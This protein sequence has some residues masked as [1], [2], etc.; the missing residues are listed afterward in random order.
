MHPSSRQFLGLFAGFT[1]VKP[2]RTQDRQA[3][4]YEVYPVS[5]PSH[6]DLLLGIVGPATPILS[7]TRRWSQ[8]Q[9][10]FFK[11]FYVKGIYKRRFRYNV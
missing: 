4:W 9:V 7:E 11:I 2:S 5:Q 3:F 6:F 8:Y 10:P 1:D